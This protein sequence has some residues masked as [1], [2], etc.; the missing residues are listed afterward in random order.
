MP[1]HVALNLTLGAG[2]CFLGFRM[3]IAGDTRDRLMGLA[4]IGTRTLLA[5]SGVMPLTEWGL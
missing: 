2:L 1:V 3:L 5:T 4:V